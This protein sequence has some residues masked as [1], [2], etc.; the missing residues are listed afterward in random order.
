[1]ENQKVPI[2]MYHSVST[3]ASP[4]FRKFTVTPALFTEHLRYLKE[5][6]YTSLTVSQFVEAKEKLPPRPVILTFDDGFADFY[7]TVL[8]L[9]KKS[10]FTATLYVTTGVAG[11][12]SRW[13]QAEGEADRPMLTWEQLRQIS[14]NGI[15]CGGHS[16]NHLQLDAVP[17]AT[18]RAEIAGCKTVLETQLGHKI[19]SFAYPFGYHS[20]KVKQL[21]QE[22]GYRSACAVKYAMSSP[23]DDPFALSRLIVEA[24]ISLPQFARLLEGQTSP[25]MPLFKKV[26]TPAWQMARRSKAQLARYS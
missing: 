17:L 20:R 26:I 24:D 25:L 23:Q 10:G 22:A 8:P 9:L 2:L 5:N 13:L 6:N 18:A 4:K 15:E 3:S 12:T 11:S 16:Q 19:A 14:A 7:T 21:V 1:M